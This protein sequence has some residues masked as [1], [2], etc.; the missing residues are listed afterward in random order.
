[1]V[2]AMLL[3]EML[4]VPIP[5]DVTERVESYATCLGVGDDMIRVVRRIASGSLGL[6]LIDF[7]RSGYFEKLLDEPPAHLHTRA[8]SPTCGSSPSDDDT[9]FQ[10]W[11]ELERCPEGS[12]GPGCMAFYQARGFTFPGRPNSAPPTLAQHDWIHVLADYGSTVESEI[13]VF[14]LIARAQRR[15]RTPSRCSR[16]APRAVQDRPGRRLPGHGR[17]R[18]VRRGRH[19]DFRFNDVMSEEAQRVGVSGFGMGI[20]IHNDIVLPYFLVTTDQQKARSLP[21]IAAGELPI[22]AVA[23]TEPGMGTD[24]ASMRTTAIRDGDDYVVDGSK[25]FITNGINA[26]LV[27]TAVKTDPSLR[28]KGIEP[29]RPRT[30]HGRLRARPHLEKVGLRSQDTAELFFTDV[31]VPVEDLLA[32]EG[33][34]LPAA[35]ARPAPGAPSI[36]V[37]AVAAAEAALDWTLEY[38]KERT[39]FG[40]PIGSFQNSRFEL[41]EMRTEIDI[42]QV[43]VDR[44]VEALNDGEL[45]AEEA[46]EAKWWC[47]ELQKRVVDRCVQLH[48]G[49]GYM[50][51][52]PIARAYMDARVTSDLRRHHRDH[53]GDHRPVAH[54]APSR[55]MTRGG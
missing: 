7:E 34:G 11:A 22:T 47:T 39:A 19:D 21:G 46:A 53:E 8:R 20:T 48:G 16:R 37:A 6:A 36:A 24:L 54:A 26:D 55:G 10:R 18:A 14:G 40:Q 12:L 29:A 4:L 31:G 15:S 45:T 44:C 32:P 38:G 27:V 41:A 23:M 3:A 50:L 30:G 17:A 28:H 25:T 42:A 33:A 13:E 52:Y 35:R 1:M 5:P 2:Q 43:F 51:E 9:L 49:Y